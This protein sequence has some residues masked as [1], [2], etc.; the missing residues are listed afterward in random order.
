MVYSDGSKLQHHTQE[1]FQASL[2][3]YWA[4]L[5]KDVYRGVGVLMTKGPPPELALPR[6]H[7]GHLLAARTGHGDFAAY[8]QRWNHQ[9]AL[10]TC[11]CGRD[12]T[13][14]HFFF[15]WKGRRAGRI[16]TPPPPLCVGPKEAITWILGTKEGAKAFSSWCSKTA[17]FN[18]IQRRF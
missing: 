2:Q 16:S 3:G 4:S 7:L 8:H 11:S 18:T 1:R 13:P 14:E 17:F 10:L 15:C 12:K 6:K 9:D 5:K